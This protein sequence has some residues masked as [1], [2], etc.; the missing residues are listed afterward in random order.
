M[1]SEIFG[2]P[3]W[4]FMAVAAQRLIELLIANRNTARLLK[5]G[6]IEVGRNHYFLIVLLHA[7]WLVALFLL[8]PPDQALNFWLF[9]V[10]VVLQGARVWVIASLGP[11]W[12]TR[13][14]TLPETPL[15]AR[16][17][18]RWMR[19]PN[20]VIVALEIAILPLAL[21]DWVLAV[22][23]SIANAILMFIRI[24]TENK[25]LESRRSR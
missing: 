13:I 11:Y 15:I 1:N 19:H 17:P 12:T 6:G 4:L 22:V 5:E 24:P 21:G 2:L 3:Q 16:G 7:T 20:Y 14:I 18:Y 9:G 25:A 23:F 10:F 8:V